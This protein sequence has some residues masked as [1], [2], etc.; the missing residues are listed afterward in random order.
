METLT[1]E[2][3]MKIIGTKPEPKSK[4][5]REM[6]ESQREE[7]LTRLAKAREKVAENRAAKLEQ[8]AKDLPSKTPQNKKIDESV[9]NKVY[10]TKLDKL[11]DLMEKQ[12]SLT[13]EHLEM[14]RAKRAKKE[15]TIIDKEDKK[16]VPIK[17]TETIIQPSSLPPTCP[18][19][20]R[21]LADIPLEQPIHTPTPQPTPSVIAPPPIIEKIQTPA[22]IENIVEEP[23]VPSRSMIKRRY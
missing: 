2:E 23:F 12:L 9:F 18:P 14:K 5:K 4:K 16:D 8:Q 17:P 15:L 20:V 11:S 21:P 7:L 22:Q 1:K 13:T 6:S 3:L 10:D 19:D